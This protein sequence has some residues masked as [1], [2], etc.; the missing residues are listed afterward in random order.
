MTLFSFLTW[1]LKIRV[2]KN[3][4]YSVHFKATLCSN[5][6]SDHTGAGYHKEESAPGVVHL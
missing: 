5:D 4:A 3:T 1:T 2:S 6:H